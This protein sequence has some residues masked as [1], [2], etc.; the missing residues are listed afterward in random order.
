MGGTNFSSR[1]ARQGALV[2]VLLAP[3]VLYAR[4]VEVVGPI[5]GMAVGNSATFTIGDQQFGDQCDVGLGF[6]AADFAISYDRTVFEYVRTDY[7]GP[8]TLD[9]SLDFFTAPG[10]GDAD[11]AGTFN[12]QLVLT[13]SV[14]SGPSDIFSVTFKAIAASGAGGTMFSVSPLTD[15]PSYVF[16]TASVTVSV[17]PEPST[18]LMMSAALI[19]GLIALR[20][21]R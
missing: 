7:A 10:P 12:V 14:P 18:A 21:Q 6:C 17:V 8:V 13:S 5:G 3:A 16:Q 4:D 19:A 2:L 1:I 15:A 9:P 11:P 20:R